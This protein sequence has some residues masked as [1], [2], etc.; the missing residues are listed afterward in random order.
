MGPGL[1]AVGVKG[2]IISNIQAHI[3]Q[4]DL[5]EGKMIHCDG[6][7]A[8]VFYRQLPEKQGAVSTGRQCDREDNALAIWRKV[9]TDSKQRSQW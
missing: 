8:L 2:Q 5:H 4:G 7:L 3:T 9:V 6:Q 1:P